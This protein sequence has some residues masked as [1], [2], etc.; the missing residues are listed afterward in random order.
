MTTSIRRQFSVSDV[1]NEYVWLKL[2]QGAKK[3]LEF[4]AYADSR[5]LESLDEG[6]TVTVT[7]KSRNSQNTEWEIEEVD[8][9][10]SSES[11]VQAPA[12]D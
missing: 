3:G 7:M 12:D 4:A 10:D 6:D 9:L 11:R 8:E 1:T 2:L 5:T